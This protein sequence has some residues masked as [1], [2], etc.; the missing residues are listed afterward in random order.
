LIKPSILP[1][2]KKQNTLIF[3]FMMLRIL[4]FFLA[5]TWVLL[6][7]W[8]EFSIFP[9]IFFIVSWGYQTERFQ[10]ANYFLIYAFFCSLPFFIIIQHHIIFLRVSSV[11][12][13]YRVATK[14]F[15]FLLLPFLVKLPFFLFHLWLPKAHV[16]APTCGSIILAAVLLKIGGYGVLRLLRCFFINMIFLLFLGVVGS[17]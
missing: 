17:L 3:T 12:F 10:A 4:F 9:I 16:E 7:V 1:L 11:T 6:F 2:L 13:F 5:K 15:V 8:F 14:I